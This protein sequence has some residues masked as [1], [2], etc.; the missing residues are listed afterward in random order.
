VIHVK[1]SSI[2]AEAFQDAERVIGILH[3]MLKCQD[4]PQDAVLKQIA[5]GLYDL[6]LHMRRVLPHIDSWYRTEYEKMLDDV[7]EGIDTMLHEIK[8]NQGL[9]LSPQSTAVH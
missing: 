6:H 9:R 7:A 4:D 8:I 3:G 5:R 1:P 2:T